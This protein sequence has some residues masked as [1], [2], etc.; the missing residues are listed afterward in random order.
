M[1]WRHSG[2]DLMV[3]PAPAAARPRP[4]SCPH[5]LQ[6]QARAAP[7]RDSSAVLRGRGSRR[8]GAERKRRLAPTRATSCRH[9]QPRDVRTRAT[10]ATTRSIWSDLPRPARRHRR[11][12]RALSAQLAALR[13]PLDILIATPGRLLD[14]IQSGKAVLETRRDA[15]AR[16]S[17][18]H[19]RHGLHRR[20][21]PIASRSLRRARR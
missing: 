1:P 10:V 11:R 3:Q 21:P 18:P 20:H 6:R 16:R 12:R 14:H 7:R 17:R 19:A 5:P 9:A 13:G 8:S 4:S 15:G 2:R